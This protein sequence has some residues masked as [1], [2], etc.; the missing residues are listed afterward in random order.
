MK[1]ILSS[2]L[3]IVLFARLI[4]AAEA[5]PKADWVEPMQKVHAGFTGTSGYVAQ[6]GDSITYSMAF[7]KPM[8]WSDPDQYLKDDGLPK[9]PEKRW[10]D[11][12]QG[13]GDDGKGPAAGNYSGWRVGDLLKAVPK[14]LAT[15]KP[16]AAIIMIGTNDISGGSVPA[17]YQPGLEKLVQ[18]CLDA[19]CIPI[20]NTIP[21]KRGQT[22]A[23][24]AANKIIRDVAAKHHIPLVDY[25]AAILAH[26]PDGKWDGTL[27][28]AD[29]VHPSGGATQDYS[30]ANL[31]KSGYAVRNWV[32]FL[33]FREVYF[34]V[35]AGK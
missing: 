10:R 26:A 18:L 35:L 25:H 12:I 27:I 15:K 6:F 3:T 16:E 11:V 23:V 24:D 1:F 30:D 20:L 14:A 7:W 33:M 28:S 13:A 2:V 31:R 9:R 19:K 22:E 17:D 21:P 8:S 4:L 32:N 29:G 5:P 34:R